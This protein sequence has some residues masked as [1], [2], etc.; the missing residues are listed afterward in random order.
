MGIIALVILSVSIGW[1]A[2]TGGFNALTG[3]VTGP[4]QYNWFESGRALKRFYEYQPPARK[5]VVTDI[6]GMA[7]RTADGT[8][9]TKRDRSK[10]YP[11]LDKNIQQ[12]SQQLSSPVAPLPAAS[13]PQPVILQEVAPLRQGQIEE[14]PL[15]PSV[16]VTSVPVSSEKTWSLGRRVQFGLKA[17]NSL[18]RSAELTLRA[19]SQGSRVTLSGIVLDQEEKDYIGAQAERIA[20]AGN[21]DNRLTVL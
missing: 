1:A 20:G 19:V 21:V 4:R 3:G 6:S 14:L 10:P 13:M 18:S 17:D 2:F 12:D 11:R 16:A 9:P 5:A 8:Q 15:A 7:Y